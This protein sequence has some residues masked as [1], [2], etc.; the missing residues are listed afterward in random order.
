MSQRKAGEGLFQLI[1]SPD[2]DVRSLAHEPGNVVRILL[3]RGREQWT[4]GSQCQCIRE[5]RRLAQQLLKG[6]GLFVSEAI[7]EKP[8]AFLIRQIAD[9]RFDFRVKTLHADILRQKSHESGV[10]SLEPGVEASRLAVRAI[11]RALNCGRVTQALLWDRGRPRPLWRNAKQFQ[12]FT[13][14]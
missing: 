1:A 8:S 14:A 2:S 11:Q 3:Q 4:P 7:K 6:D 5:E 12:L 9:Q 13:D 10:I